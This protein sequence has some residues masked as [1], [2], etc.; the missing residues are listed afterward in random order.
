[1]ESLCPLGWFV[2]RQEAGP[3]PALVELQGKTACGLVV[4]PRKWSPIRCITHGEKIVS[5]A[6]QVLIGAGVGCD[7]KLEV[8]PDNPFFRARIKNETRTPKMQ[9]I[10]AKAGQVWGM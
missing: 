9:D 10:I 2:F 8:E 7:A 4:E 1:M 3:C 5:A 6:A